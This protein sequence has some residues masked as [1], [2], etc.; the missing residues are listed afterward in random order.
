[1]CLKYVCLAYFILGGIIF[2]QSLSKSSANVKV[3]LLPGIMVEI[4]NEENKPEVYP[5]M[6]SESFDGPENRG[7]LLRL[8]RSRGSGH[9]RVD[10]SHSFNEKNEALL[11]YKPASQEKIELKRVNDF[12]SLEESSNE[13]YNEIHFRIGTNKISLDEVDQNKFKTITLSLTYN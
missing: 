11:I 10:V 2:A 6:I 13:A 3:K 7:L 5:E 9:I 1:V 12:K 4:I 8:V